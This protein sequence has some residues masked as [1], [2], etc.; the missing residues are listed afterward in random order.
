MTFS[1]ETP[2]ILCC[3]PIEGLM[4]MGKRESSGLS[5]LM[6][7]SLQSPDQLVSSCGSE[8]TLS[9]RLP[10]NSLFLVQWSLVRGEPWLHLQC[11]WELHS[12]HHLAGAANYCGK[13]VL[14]RVGRRKARKHFLIWGFRGISQ[15]RHQLC[16]GFNPHQVTL[17]TLEMITQ[18]L[19]WK[20]HSDLF[21]RVM[22]VDLKGKSCENVYIGF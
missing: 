6:K 22:Y 16:F 20:R 10:C 3:S 5:R 7:G 14:R 1:D 12:G 21:Y 18:V 19:L 8:L 17:V 15:F 4:V 9:A 13:Q 2:Q 11:L